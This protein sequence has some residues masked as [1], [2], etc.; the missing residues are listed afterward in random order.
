MNNLRTYLH[1][2]LAGADLAVELLENL[3]R[4]R[5]DDITGVLAASILI[6][7][8]EDRNTLN[9]FADDVESGSS[10]TK[11]L[12]AWVGE[13][14][15]RMKLD[16]KSGDPFSSFQA[17]E[18]LALGVLGKLHLWRTLQVAT[19]GAATRVDLD[20]SRLIA[21]AE[22]QYD[23]LEKRRLQLAVLTLS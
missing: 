7:V 21:R 9:H 1:D 4:N 16:P 22:D 20:L 17:L 14:A 8:E 23:R 11:E 13:K 3:S 10:I 19:L 12:A 2:H 18:F 5:Q 15:V 6:E